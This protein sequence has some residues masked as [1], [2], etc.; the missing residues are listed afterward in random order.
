MFLVDQKGDPYG[1]QLI[2]DILNRIDTAVPQ[3]HVFLTSQL[4][5]DAE[6]R[7]ARLGYLA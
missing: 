5:L 6:A 3:A 2:Q 1:P 4:A 7:A